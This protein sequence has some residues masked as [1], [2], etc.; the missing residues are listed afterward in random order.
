MAL[1]SVPLAFLRGVRVPYPKAKDDIEA[2]I[3]QALGS[4]LDYLFNAPKLFFFTVRSRFFLFVLPG[5]AQERRY[6]VF[7]T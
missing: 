3:F 5:R 7:P 4:W 1:P 2:E 6:S